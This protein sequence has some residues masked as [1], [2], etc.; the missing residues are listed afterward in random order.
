[1][2]VQL[3]PGVNFSEIDLTTIVPAASSTDTA[4]SGVFRWGPVGEIVLVDSAISLV[5]RFGKPTNFNAETFFT[6]YNFLSYSNRLYISRAANGSGATP[7]VSISATSGSPNVAMTSTTGLTAGMY[8]TQTSNTSVFTPSTRLTIAS[9]TNSTSVVLSQNA[10]ATNSAVTLYFGRPETAYNALALEEGGIVA[11][12]VHQIIPNENVYNAKDGALD[13]DVLY[14]AKYPGDM[15][16][17]LRVAVCDTANAYS[18]NVS[19]AIDFSYAIGANSSSAQFSGTSNAAGIAVGNSFIDGDKILVGNSSIGYQYL[20]VAGVTVNTSYNSNTLVTISFHD[21]FRLHT[22]YSSNVVQRYWEFHNLVD[23]APGQSDFVLASGNTSANDELHIVVVDDGGKFTGTPGTVLEVYQGLS[24]ASDAKSAD[25]TVNYYKDVLNINSNYIWWGND[26]STSLSNTAVN[27]ASSSSTK[28]GSF[29]MTLGSDGYDEANNSVFSV[30][31]NGYDLFKSPENIDISLV[32]QGKPTGSAGSTYQLANY[33]IENI[34]EVR[35]DCIV[36][37]S[38]DKSNVLNNTGDETLDLI[39]WR[40]NVTSSS[41][42]VIDSG[43]K[44]QYDRY[45]DIYRWV[46]M[47]GDIAGLCVRTDNTND[48]WWSPAGFNRGQIKNVVKIAFNPNKADRDLLYSNGINPVVTFPGQGTVLYGDKTAQAKPSA[49]DRINVRRLFIVLEKAI[50]QAA[51]YSLFEFNDQFTRA[52]FKNLVIPYLRTIQ[53]RRGITDFEVVCDERNN[54][55]QII[56]SNQFVGDIYIKPAR[57]I[58]FIQLNFVAVATGVQ[59]S[60]VIGRF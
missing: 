30:V 57:S 5:N 13:T 12:L 54:T 39:A 16:N 17:S 35:K 59:F 21:T 47:N 1:M 56:D 20:E 51:K 44:Y 42:G 36:L 29:Q 14:L 23:T 9:V 33:L 27:V 31:A 43:Y 10:A 40:K 53:G 24:R 26:R 50:S 52:Q 45:N 32:L 6:A 34:A 25:N 2:A 58:N 60:E 37:I 22:S 55:A 7:N 18:S 3:S 28:P 48:A 49:F 46:P 8:V 4:F 38:P 15:G 41:Y 11:N 19:S